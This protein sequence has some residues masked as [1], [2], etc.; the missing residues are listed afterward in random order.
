MS[1]YVYPVLMLVVSNIIFWFKG[2]SRELFQIEWTPFRWW[3]TTSLITNYL[4][5]YAWWR[6]I[7]LGDVWK[8]GVVWGMVSLNTDLILN[9]FYFGFNARG[10]VALVLC[11]C[12][13]L[14]AHK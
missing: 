3:L 1:A 6:L 2:N 11:A 7:Q 9:I 13:G 8:A 4:T 12:A 14:I 10:V 5:L